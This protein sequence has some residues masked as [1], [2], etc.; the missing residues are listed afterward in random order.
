MVDNRKLYD[1]TDQEKEHLKKLG[2]TERGI[3]YAKPNGLPASKEEVFAALKKPISGSTTTQKYIFSQLLTRAAEQRII[4]NKTKEAREWFRN[5]AS[6]YR[7]GG[8]DK[9]RF[10]S[11]SVLS[12]S[13]IPG[14]MFM[15]TYDAKHK[16]TLPYWD[17]FP[18]IFVINTFPGGFDGLNLHYLQP[19]LRARLMDAL[20]ENLNNSRFDDTT[21]IMVNYGVLKSASNLSLFKPCYKSYLYSQV[22][23]RFI[24]VEPKEWD[25]AMFLPLQNFQKATAQ[26]VWRESANAV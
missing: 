13:V 15:F 10:F 26:Q 24:Y 22:R 3:G 21:R 12:N 25:I 23:S 11:G 7:K 14:R 20:Y 2:F 6:N 5:K 18:L 4:P 8:L 1:L 9:N 16:D 19:M 17:A